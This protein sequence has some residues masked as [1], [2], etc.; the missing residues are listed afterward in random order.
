MGVVGAAIKGF[1]KALRG[2]KKVIN[3]TTGK[4]FPESIQ[5]HMRAADKRTTSMKKAGYKG[6]TYRPSGKKS[7]TGAHH[8]EEVWTYN[9]YKTPKKSRLKKALTSK[10]TKAFGKGALI[11]GAAASGIEYK[12][13]KDRG[14]YKK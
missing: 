3:R 5:R 14:D 13:R 8:L 6:P 2:P 11:G 1:G 10:E 4:P 7:K 9:P 12:R